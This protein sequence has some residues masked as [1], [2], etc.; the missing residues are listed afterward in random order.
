MQNL[1]QGTVCSPSSTPSYVHKPVREVE[2]E[3]MIVKNA[4]KLFHDREREAGL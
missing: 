1:P 4:F 3:S 2:M